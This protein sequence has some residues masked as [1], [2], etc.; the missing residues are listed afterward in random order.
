MSTNCTPEV[1][2]GLAVLVDNWDSLAISAPNSQGVTAADD[3]TPS[4]PKQER[5]LS[6]AWVEGCRRGIGDLTDDAWARIVGGIRKT[7]RVACMELLRR[8]DDARP[9]FADRDVDDDADMLD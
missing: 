7:I 2:V 1:F 3:A 8:T 5:R 4:S 9:L 6:S